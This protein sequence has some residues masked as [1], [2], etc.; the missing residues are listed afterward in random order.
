[1]FTWLERAWTLFSSE[2]DHSLNING[3]KLH[4]DERFLHV[5]RGSHACLLSVL[6]IGPLW[7][8]CKAPGIRSAEKLKAVSMP[9]SVPKSV[10]ET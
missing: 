2:R 7:T 1:M 6:L 10:F 3:V 8:T 9:V 5:R 4:E